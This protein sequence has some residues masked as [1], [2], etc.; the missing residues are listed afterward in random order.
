MAVKLM[1]LCLFQISWYQINLED[2]VINVVT[3]KLNKW[4]SDLSEL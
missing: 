3:K 4:S 1:L 2:A